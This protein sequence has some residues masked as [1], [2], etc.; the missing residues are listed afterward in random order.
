MTYQKARLER[1]AT[2][3]VLRED[4]ELA[5][6]I[7]AARRDRAED[8]CIAR[9]L[10]VRRGRWSSQPG[11]HLG[12]GIGLLVVD[13]FLLRRIGV[14]GRFG[15]E[16]L[17]PGDLLRPA[18]TADVEP[19][20]R[21]ATAWRALESAQLAVLDG[22]AT[23]HLVRYP[24]VIERLVARTTERSRRLVVNMAIVHH[25]RV[26]VRLH[27]TFWHLADHWGHVW[28]PN[29]PAAAAYAH[30]LGGSDRCPPSNRQ[31]GG[32]GSGAPR[33]PVSG[34]ARLAACRR[35]TGSTVRARGRRRVPV[36]QA[37]GR[38]V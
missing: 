19:M 16:L 9:K 5:D 31:H 32:V 4:P 20:L 12:D 17:G 21:Q 35:A 33:D 34:P 7:P 3:H 13:G 1:F 22:S 26:D 30:R 8:A 11:G 38:R 24:E 2:C 14:G 36:D 27:M 28:W 25:P 29:P 6:G 10:T 18:D 23:K 15:A 37:L